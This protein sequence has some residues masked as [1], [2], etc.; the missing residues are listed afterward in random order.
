MH[1]NIFK[2]LSNLTPWQPLI[3]AKKSHWLDNHLHH[4]NMVMSFAPTTNNTNAQTEGILCCKGQFS[5]CLRV[6]DQCMFMISLL[7]CMISV[8]VKTVVTLTLSFGSTL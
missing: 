2:T 1:S 7:S 8:W 3:T 6:K 5:V 4:P